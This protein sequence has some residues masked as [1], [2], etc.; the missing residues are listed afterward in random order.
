MVADLIGEAVVWFALVPMGD[1]RTVD[2]PAIDVLDDGLAH[3]V[4]G[5][6]VPYAPILDRRCEQGDDVEFASY[7]EFREVL[8]DDFTSVY[9]LDARRLE[10][11]VCRERVP[12]APEPAN[13]DPVPTTG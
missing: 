5:W 10:A 6:A 9:D 1:G 7:R 8:G 11:V 4:N 2:L 12:Y 13:A 3:L